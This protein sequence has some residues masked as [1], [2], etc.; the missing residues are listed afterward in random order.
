MNADLILEVSGLRIDRARPGRNDTIVS[1][2]SLSLAAG[3]T[4]GIVGESGSGKSMTARAI[5]G[6]L[7]PTLTAHGEVRY[8]GRNLLE[9]RERGGAAGAGPRDRPD[10]AGPVHNAQPGHPLREDPD[11]IA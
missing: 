4:I 1:S 11:R 6:L 10:H 7:P 3:E 9:L 2:V 5:T 8:G